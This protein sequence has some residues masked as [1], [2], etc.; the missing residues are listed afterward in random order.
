M[1]ILILKMKGLSLLV[2]RL[3][4]QRS[5]IGRLNV[6]LT[7]KLVMV[8]RENEGWYQISLNLYK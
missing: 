1:Q 6:Y 8:A 2:L 7:E 5:K 4:G 3:V